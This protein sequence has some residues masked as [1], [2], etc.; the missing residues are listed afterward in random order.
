MAVRTIKQTGDS[1]NRIDLIILGDG[2]TSSEIS[3]TFTQHAQALT[4]YLFEGGL[5][6]EPFDRY[7]QYFNVHLVDVISNES[8]ADIGPEGIFRDTALNSKYYWDGSTERL[9][10]IDDSAADSV[11]ASELAGTGIGAEMTFVSVNSEKYGGGGGRHAVYAGGNEFSLEVALH[12]IGHSFADLADTYGGAPGAYS[13]SEPAAVNA[14]L[15]STG[16]KWSH[17]LGYNQEGVGT[18][19]AYEG[20][21]YHDTGVYRP[22]E[23]SKMRSLDQPFDVVAREAFILEFY[24]LVDPIDS[25]S[26]QG[27]SGEL[28]DITSLS[29]D[30]IDTSTIDVDWYVDGVRVVSG[31]DSVSISD[32]GLA[33]GV[34]N[35]S[36]K[37]YDNA[38]WV[39]SDR[40]TLE[41][42]VSWNV[43]LSATELNDTIVGNETGNALNGLG[44]DDQI[45][46]G[47][48]DD[49]L[50]GGDGIDSAL[51]DALQ[52]SVSVTLNKDGSILVTDRNGSEGTDTL[53]DIETVTFTD[54]TLDLTQFV[55]TANLTADQF[56]PLAEMY[57]AYFNRAPDATG[58]Y[59][60]ADKLA[61][62][63]SLNQI[64]E[65]F[66]DQAETR[67]L[68][69][70]PSNTDAFVTAVYDNVLGR[71]PDV[72]GFDFWKGQV[73]SGNVSQ[74]AFV[75]EVIQGAKNGG[76]AADV[77]YLSQKTDLGIYFSAIKGMSDVADATA[78]FQTFGEASTSN[79]AGAR[80]EVDQHYSDAT[81]ANGG[82]FLF[83]VIG[84]I[85][86]PF[87]GTVA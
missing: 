73:S 42:T 81:T 18:I 28:T 4:N 43:R 2:Y 14:T 15:D 54:T 22:S 86:D 51:Y 80:A 57:A 75:L 32:L 65:L 34:F 61:E 63:L 35:I 48:G 52:R 87:S 37:A 25:Y 24:K 9:L 31:R 44:G 36:A 5:L 84:V 49:Y 60:W 66:F 40:S 76:S 59:F 6:A 74:G 23:N 50:V 27:N 46:G 83:S 12:E 11:I 39:R 13:G 38:D 30:T 17:W 62:G 47:G 79:L 64:A 56:K 3:T 71:T 8:G 82:D 69:T 29:V 16:S 77:Q 55:S 41:Q 26:F 58:L 68:Y 53:A 72:S 78:V 21:V 70:D 33:A 85:D 1:S 45:K 67:A 10:Y 20:A 7:K 19:G